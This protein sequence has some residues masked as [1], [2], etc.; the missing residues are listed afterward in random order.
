MTQAAA[1]ATIGVSLPQYQ[2]YEAGRSQPTLDVIRAM[3]VA[4]SVSADALIFEPSERGPGD[5]LALQFEAVAQFDD[6]EKRLVRA[7]LEGLIIR[8]DA[9]KWN[10]PRTP[11]KHS[12]AEATP[13]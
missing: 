12:L 7:L 1:A 5:D 6:D 4:F 3:A 2:R 13:Q 8:H 11:A 10:P 9:Q